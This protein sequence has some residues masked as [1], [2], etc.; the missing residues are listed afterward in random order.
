MAM[1][2]TIL[3]GSAIILATSPVLAAE[4]TGD[5]MVAEGAAHIRIENC[6]G[7][8]WG[9]VAWEK[10]P[11]GKD[12]QNPD[13]AKRNRPTLGIPILIDM[14]PAADGTR[15][16]G[17]VYNAEN[18]KTYTANITIKD[19]NTLRIEGCVLGFLCGGQNWTRV[20]GTAAQAPGAPAKK[21]GKN[22]PKGKGAVSEV[23]SRVANLAGATH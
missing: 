3:I 2:L 17:Q 1:R 8:L 13:P 12:T 11:G 22:T 15:W 21:D 16:D 4:P 19:P 7:A 23:C 5:W 18:G 6:A 10:V 9:V 14:K 20:Q